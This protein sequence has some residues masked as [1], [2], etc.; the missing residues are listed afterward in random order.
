[1]EG[2]ELVKAA[3]II[4]VGAIYV[5]TLLTQPIEPASLA[6]VLSG[7]VG[8]ITTILGINIGQ[9]MERKRAGRR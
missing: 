2:W 4:T 3:A 9:R 1:M 7:A 8:A 6:A 5:T